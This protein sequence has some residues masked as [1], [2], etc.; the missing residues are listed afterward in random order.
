M[1]K[2]RHNTQTFEVNNN[3]NYLRIAHIHLLYYVGELCGICDL[4][5]SSDSY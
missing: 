1:T 3:T 4:H 5:D 2:N